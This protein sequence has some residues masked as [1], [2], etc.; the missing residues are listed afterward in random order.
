VFAQGKDWDRFVHGLL[1]VA[2]DNRGGRL[3]KPL[4]GE[5]EDEDIAT[6]LVEHTDFWTLGLDD[7][8]QI[9]LRGVGTCP[10]DGAS[11]STARAIGEILGLARKEMEKPEAKKPSRSP[12]EENGIRI[13]RSFFTNMRVERD[14]RSVLVQ[15]AGFGTLADYASLV[16]AGAVDFP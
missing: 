14:G 5:P 15:S 3:A 1:L 6:P 9:V 8:D 2:L 7:N 16:V 10:N 13:A 12:G 4:R 11:E